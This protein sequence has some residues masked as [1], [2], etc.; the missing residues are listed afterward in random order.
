VP[1][2]TFEQEAL[3]K[4]MVR[5]GKTQEEISSALNRRREVIVLKLKCLQPYGNC[6][7]QFPSREDFCLHSSLNKTILQST[8]I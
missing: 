5:Q 7:F 8:V 3:L 4:E 2:W 6:L 1:C